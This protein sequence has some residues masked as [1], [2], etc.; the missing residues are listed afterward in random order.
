MCIEMDTWPT[1]HEAW[2]VL[3]RNSWAWNPIGLVQSLVQNITSHVDRMMFC[4]FFFNWKLLG[5]FRVGGQDPEYVDPRVT[6]D[7]GEGCCCCC[8][9]SV[10]E[11]MQCRVDYDSRERLLQDIVDVSSERF[12]PP[13]FMIS[14]RIANCL[15][16][17]KVGQVHYFERSRT[18]NTVQW[19]QI[20]SIL[21]ESRWPLAWGFL[22]WLRNLCIMLINHEA[23]MWHLLVTLCHEYVQ[24]YGHYVKDR[25]H[26]LK[27]FNSDTWVW[28]VCARQ[29]AQGWLIDYQSLLID[30]D[31][32]VPDR[33]H[34][35]D[36]LTMTI[37][38]K[39]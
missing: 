11:C 18:L 4:N 15:C 24:D 28:P 8:P 27:S 17:L 36:S 25:G 37:M 22:L 30:C 31:H 12:W 26:V 38:C 20:Q 6:F 7:S 13:S 1:L 23:F 5:L 14:P 19:N 33:G 9:P 21:K 3:R 16:Y 34:R 10:Q 2:N 29:R 32:Y 35:G 39:T